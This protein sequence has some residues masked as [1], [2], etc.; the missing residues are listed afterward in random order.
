MN[1]LKRV[2]VKVNAFEERLSKKKVKL[3][4]SIIGPILTMA[5]SIFI[6]LVIPQ[7]INVS[8]GSV[9]NGRTLPTLAAL[10]ILVI[11]V[12]LLIKEI[13]KIVVQKKADYIELNL[14]DEIKTLTVIA[15]LFLYRY[16]IEWIGFMA[17]S[18]VFVVLFLGLFKRKK[19]YY[20]LIVIGFAIAVPLLFKNALNVRLP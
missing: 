5:F 18:S 20:Y 19:W 17:A 2:F 6:L 12:I 10:I 7:Q 15:L 8:E 3:Y 11:S 9:T 4:K 13:I 1:I 16:A 14:L